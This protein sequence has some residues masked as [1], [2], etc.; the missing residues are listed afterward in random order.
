MSNVNTMTER[1]LEIID[2]LYEATKPVGVSKIS[3]D[4]SLPKAT[5]FRILVTLEQW[6]FVRK[7]ED[8]DDYKLGLGLIK[9]G[10]KVASQ[11]NLVDIAKPFINTLSVQLGESANLNIEYQ[12]QSLNIYKSETDHSILVSKLTPISALNCSA[13]GKIF[14]SNWEPETLK[15]YFIQK[16]FSDRTMNSITDY[17]DFMKEL[18]SIT[19]NGIAYDNEEYE[20]GLFCLSS[21]IRHKDSIVA[22]ISISGPKT[23]LEHKGF[24]IITKELKKVCGEISEMISELNLEILF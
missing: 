21:P 14:L 22:A 18:Q 24:D 10:S 9:Y 1:T 19:E 7:N 8:T 4:L 11:T 23:R 5:V 16:Q 12:G 15:N 17:E 2:Y 20:Y 6:N 13:S 3:A